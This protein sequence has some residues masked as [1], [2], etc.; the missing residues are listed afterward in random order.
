MLSPYNAVSWSKWFF[1]KGNSK[2]L[3]ASD[4]PE[5]RMCFEHIPT[6]LLVPSAGLQHFLP[7][8]L[9]HSLLLTW[10]IFIPAS[11]AQQYVISVA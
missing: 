3:H 4:R 11:H 9:K 5:I 7:L 10:L 8:H 2:R 1:S 6:R